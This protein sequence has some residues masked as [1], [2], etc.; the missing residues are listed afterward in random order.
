[1]YTD[2]RVWVHANGSD[3]VVSANCTLLKYVTPTV[4]YIVIDAW[5]F[6]FDLKLLSTQVGNFSVSLLEASTNLL[7]NS[8]LIPVLNR[9]LCYIIAINTILY[10]VFC[11]ICKC[12]YCHT[13]CG[14]IVFCWSTIDAWPGEDEIHN[15]SLIIVI[16]IY[17]IRATY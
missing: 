3:E 17:S 6:R 16:I 13:C 5:F 10:T 8:F 15:Y 11:R 14:W 4:Y 12:W 9:K 7:V 2:V 1:M